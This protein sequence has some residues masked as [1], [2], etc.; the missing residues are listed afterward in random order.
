[1][2]PGWS[3]APF[4]LLLV[5]GE[6]EYLA[7]SAQR[8]EAFATL[9]GVR[10]AGSP[11]LWRTRTQP[12]N[13]LAAFPAFGPTPT[14]VVGTPS[15]TG[16]SSRRWVLSVL[17]EHFHQLQYSR[18]GY[19]ADVEAL[20]LSGGD[21]TGMWMLDYPFPYDSAAANEE[22]AAL[23]RELAVLVDDR[24]AREPE[25]P[26]RFWC[27]LRAFLQTLEPADRRYL[28]FQLWQ[29]GIAR[30]VELQ[31]AAAA[32][33]GHR[34]TAA[35]EALADDE[36]YAALAPRLQAAVVSSLQTDALKTKRREIFYAF[37]AA[38]G[39]LLDRQGV[40]WKRAYLRDKFQLD[41]LAGVDCPGRERSPLGGRG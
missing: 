26:R 28:S 10:L 25:R 20:G 4:D 40:D 30:Y 23:S 39:L 21:K 16:K 15:A 37:G 33:T 17:H 7:R 18:P 35:F 13:L 22:F 14:I 2:W 41:G 38:L 32:V 27:R 34:S 1:M 24:L 8:P 11:V 3:E 29:E 31:L 9:D 36:P 12:A 19:F 6:F 5:D